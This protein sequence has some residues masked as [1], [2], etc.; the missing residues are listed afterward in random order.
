M[1][2][3]LY[4][5]PRALVSVNKINSWIRAKTG[6]DP[7]LIINGYT[8]AGAPIGAGP[9]LPFV[10]PFG[11]AAMLHAGNQAWLNAL[12]GAIAGAAVADGDYYG[13]TLKMQAMI[14][15]SGNAWKP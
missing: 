9:D 10:A 4:G 13:N 7:A 1:D 6:G 5:D 2:Y 15:M 8:L 14:V 12:W 11:V 3:L